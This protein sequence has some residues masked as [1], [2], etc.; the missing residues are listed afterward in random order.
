M[1]PSMQMHFLLAGRL[2]MRA[3]V[4]YP[5]AA[6]DER[7]IIPVIS[8]LLR[9]PQGNMLFDTGCH[10]DVLQNAP[11]RW[12]GL[13]KFMRPVFDET[14]ALPAQLQLTG[15]ALDDIDLIVCSHLHV[16]HCGCNSLFPQATVIC[17]A[18]ELAAAQEPEAESLGLHRQEWDTGQEIRT[19]TGQYDL[20]GDGR[21][22]LLPM[23]G[24]TRGSMAAHIVLDGAG[25]FLLASDAA[26][27]ADNLDRRH[28][29]RNSWD[30]EKTV[31]SFDEIARLRSDGAEVIYGH[32]DVQWQGLKKGAA[33]YA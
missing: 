4:Y 20:F 30:I 15:L 31:Q 32:D 29:P 7:I 23:P 24:H 1:A 33:F 6:P 28:A 26:A 18:E 3:N 13:E 11:A 27:V 21:A 16:D 22:T 19:V 10:P 12:R 8:T 9:H 17:H 25:A 14:E 5:N 2:A